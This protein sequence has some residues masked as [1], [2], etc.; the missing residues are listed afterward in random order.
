MYLRLARCADLPIISEIYAVGFHD[1]E[2]NR[3]LHPYR[4]RYPKDY[5]N[6]WR[7]RCRE[8]Y[9]NYGSVF[10]VSCEKDGTTGSEVVVGVA[11]WQRIGFGWDKFW[12]LGGFWDPR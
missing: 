5:L 1:E 8:R 3:L 4:N 10:L 6:Y 11:E 2:V 12:R 9:W 7:R